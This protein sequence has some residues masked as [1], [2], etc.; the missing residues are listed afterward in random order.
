[1]RLLLL[2]LLLLLLDAVSIALPAARLNGGSTPSAID[3]ARGRC[4]ARGA[5]VAAAT[6]KPRN[7]CCCA[8][9]ERLARTAARGL[10]AHCKP[11][12]P[13]CMV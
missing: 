2:L 13:P 10:I 6:R 1:M 4:A 7:A 5:R 12:E 11:T 9:H 8:A 3:D